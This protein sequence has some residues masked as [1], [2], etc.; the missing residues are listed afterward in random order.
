MYHY[1]SNIMN[2]ENDDIY[3]RMKRKAIGAMRCR[4]TRLFTDIITK[5]NIRLTGDDIFYNVGEQC[6]G[7]YLKLHQLPYHEGFSL[8]FT[9]I[10]CPK[11]R[12]VYKHIYDNPEY[13]YG[14]R[15]IAIK[16]FGT[17]AEIA[18]A[19]L[20]FADCYTL[21]DRGKILPH[22]NPANKEYYRL[23]CM[24]ENI[25]TVAEKI[26]FR[27]LIKSKFKETICVDTLQG[28]MQFGLACGVYEHNKSMIVRLYPSDLY[29]R[30]T[31]DDGYKLVRL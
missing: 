10:Y 14:N 13:G 20:T 18:A 31:D 23:A 25:N 22:I 29:E 4:D 12:Y 16:R 3:N 2:N 21:L 11:N 15:R 30:E 8:W 9:S 26:E 6:L 17:L 19:N 27:N 28:N 1:V 24:L 5:Y 7:I